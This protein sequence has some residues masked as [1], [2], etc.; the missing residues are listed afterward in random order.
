MSVKAKLFPGRFQGMSPKMA[1]IVGYITDQHYTNPEIAEIVV[2]VDG[3]VLARLADDCGCND[4]M[5]A[6]GDLRNNWEN[7]LKCAGLD[8]AET[9][10]AWRLYNEKV[11]HA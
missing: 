4:F 7:L 6:Y 9:E 10:E 3:C 11:R 5:G 2:T 8:E 1:A